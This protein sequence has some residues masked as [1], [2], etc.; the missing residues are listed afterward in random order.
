VVSNFFH[1]NFWLGEN[2]SLG[3]GMVRSS[4][5][6]PSEP[7]GQFTPSIRQFSAPKSVRETEYVSLL[8]CSLTHAIAEV[9]SVANQGLIHFLQLRRQL[10]NPEELLKKKNM[11]LQE[12]V[13]SEAP[14]ENLVIE[15][16]NEDN[17]L[18]GISLI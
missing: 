15:S 4:V 7:S 12:A 6:S 9:T 17:P 14:I 5:E 16:K 11:K 10:Q 18:L 3:L 1:F 2:L 8:S 13:V